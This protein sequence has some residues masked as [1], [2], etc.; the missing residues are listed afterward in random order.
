MICHIID[1]FQ[2]KLVYPTIFVRVVGVSFK[3]FLFISNS[4]P[5]C[6]LSLYLSKLNYLSNIGIFA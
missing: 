1:F 5:K 6:F 2:Y 3:L 4:S